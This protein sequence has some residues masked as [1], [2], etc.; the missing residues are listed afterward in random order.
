MTEPL[1]SSLRL[2]RR[3]LFALAGDAALLRAAQ[4]AVEALPRRA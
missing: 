1:R 2:S 4:G 3:E